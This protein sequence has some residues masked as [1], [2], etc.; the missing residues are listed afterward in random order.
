VRDDYVAYGYRY[1]EVELPAI[2][3]T[4]PTFKKDPKP[5]LRFDLNK[6]NHPQKRSPVLVSL[7][8]HTK[9]VA[10]P[11]PDC[12]D[13]DTTYAGLLKRFA[14][15][16]PSADPSLINEL[17]AFTRRWVRKHL[18]PLSPTLDLTVETWLE[19]S[20]YPL[21]RK[22]ELRAE[23]LEIGKDPKNKRHANWLNSFQK[24][25]TYTE[26][27][28]ARIINAR[29]DAVK[30]DVGPVFHAIEQEVFK[31]KYFVKKIPVRDR[32]Q[33]ILDQLFNPGNKYFPTDYSAFESLFVESLM[34][35]VEF[36]LYDYMTSQ[37]NEHDD[38]MAFCREVLGGDNV[39][40][41]KWF[42]IYIHAK[43]M[44]GEMCTSLG[45]GFSNLIFTKFVAWKHKVKV[46]SVHEGDDGL[47]SSSSDLLTEWFTEL[48]LIIK[49][50]RVEAIE[51]ASFCGIIFDPEERQNITDPIKVLANFGWTSRTYFGSSRK[52]R[53]KLLRC[54]AMSLLCEYPG[55]PVLQELAL[56]ALRVT[57]SY[58]IRSFIER[59]RDVD[60]YHR[61]RLR[62]ALD[63]YLDRVEIPA[64]RTR[65]LMERKY[66]L[67][68]TK[69]LAIEEYLKNLNEIVPL[70]VDI[71]QEAH[72]DYSDYW[73]NYVRPSQ[74]Y[75]PVDTWSQMSGF[76]KEF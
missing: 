17:K 74:G 44:S 43:R 16:P 13:P 75:Y 65:M 5:H 30:C 57:R 45:N 33:Y 58:D 71:V 1:G 66:G 3:E 52:T 42:K 34:D 49:M 72:P 40:V 6:I 20:N 67:T 23:W 47:I 41:F 25:E 19:N 24:D 38:F 37:L 36:E 61:E 26:Y 62:Y 21:W 39:C 35:A 9:G 12:D 73:T 48:G 11:H 31:L 4:D 46:K 27:K 32:P 8:C 70:N 2:P 63:H 69:Q 76:V 15:K 28:H 64:L 14:L 59:R 22:E 56:Y 10:P 55:A 50:A 18:T 68:I 54:K 29:S 7:G 60:A 53:I 51:D